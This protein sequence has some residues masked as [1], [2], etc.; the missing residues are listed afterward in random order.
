MGSA[1]VI[2]NANVDRADLAPERLSMT[3]PPSA[4]ATI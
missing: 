4:S 2:S 1:G 3:L